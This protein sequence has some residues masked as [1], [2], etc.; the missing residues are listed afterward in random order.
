MHFAELIFF[1]WCVQF[2]TCSC[3]Y[4]LKFCRLRL[5]SGDPQSGEAAWRTVVCEHGWWKQ[6]PGAEERPERW[7]PHSWHRVPGGPEGWRIRD[8]TSHKMTAFWLCTQISEPRCLS[9]VLA[10]SVC[11]VDSGELEDLQHLHDSVYQQAQEWY[12]RLMGRIREQIDKQHGSMPD[13]EENIQVG[14]K[15]NRI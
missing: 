9:P 6:I 11:Q 14:S 13:K 8:H 5:Y 3:C 2:G 7:L 4:V 1:K 10:S 15:S 12:Q